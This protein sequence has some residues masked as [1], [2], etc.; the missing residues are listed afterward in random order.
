MANFTVVDDVPIPSFEFLSR[1]LAFCFRPKGRSQLTSRNYVYD[2][3]KQSSEYNHYLWYN[4]GV[5]LAYPPCVLGTS[6]ILQ[7]VHVCKTTT[8]STKAVTSKVHWPSWA[9]RK[10]WPTIVLQQYVKNL[11]LRNFL[12]EVDVYQQPLNGW[13]STFFTPTYRPYFE[14]SREEVGHNKQKPDSCV[15]FSEGSAYV[16]QHKYD[17]DGPLSENDTTDSESDYNSQ[18]HSDEGCEYYESNSGNCESDDC[19]EFSDDSTDNCYRRACSAVVVPRSVKHT[20]ECH[21]N[22]VHV[23]YSKTYSSE[24]SGYCEL[25]D[26]SDQDSYDE[27]CDKSEVNRYLA[28]ETHWRIFQE[29]ALPPRSFKPNVVSRQQMSTTNCTNKRADCKCGDV[30]TNCEWHNQRYSGGSSKDFTK[31][32]HVRFKSDSEL[33]VVHHIVAWSFAY[34]AARKGPWENYARDRDRFSRRIEYCASILEPCLSRKISQFTT[35]S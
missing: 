5:H 30:L 35:I 31:V 22:S 4:Q 6:G 24:E 18:C 17:S 9:F 16:Q 1:E 19:V 2:C 25:Q 10:S 23:H 32:K 7:W 3:F 27:T 34:R 12:Y 20:P 26:E 33:V 21:S 14:S 13:E 28:S 29:Q 8:T 15:K 11:V